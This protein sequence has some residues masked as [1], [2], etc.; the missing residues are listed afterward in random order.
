MVALF[1]F[2][3]ERATLVLGHRGRPGE[4]QQVERTPVAGRMNSQIQKGGARSTLRRSTS[5]PRMPRAI[6]LNSNAKRAAPEGT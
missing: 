3:M 6:S 5:R 2:R 4:E 1:S